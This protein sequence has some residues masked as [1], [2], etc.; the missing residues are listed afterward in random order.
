MKFF[1]TLILF[2]S[3]IS[4]I[5]AQIT[6][7]V[8]DMLPFGDSIVYHTDTTSLFLTAGDAGENQTW[9]YSDLLQETQFTSY[10]IDPATTANAADF[11]TATHAFD[12]GGGGFYFYMENSVTESQAIGFAGDFFG[13]GNPMSNIF[14]DPQKQ[15]E[16]PMMYNTSFADNYSFSMTFDGADF[17]VDSIRFTRTATYDVEIDGWGEI[18]TPFGTYEC[19]RRHILDSYEDVIEVFQFVWIPF[20]TD[21]GVDESYEWITREAHGSV[22]TMNIDNATGETTSIDYAE[23]EALP[24]NSNYNLEDKIAIDLYPN[25][26][27]EIIY[28]TIESSNENYEVNIFDT[29]GRKVYEDN[30]VTSGTHSISLKNQ[31]TGNYLMQIK[32]TKTG[33]IA[34]KKIT[35]Q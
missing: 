26:T 24:P 4:F 8:E 35:L 21:N 19:Y 12:F 31:A 2:L 20:Q 3:C 25:P 34:T 6:F 5:Q 10:S 11:P 32:E 30:S 16:F 14:L 18:T 1:N 33:A 28:L 13:T 9:N 17:G 29:A 23:V 27:S 15:F 7:D 22:L